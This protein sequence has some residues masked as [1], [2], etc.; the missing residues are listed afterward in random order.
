MPGASP[1]IFAVEQSEGTSR[2]RLT[3]DFDVD[4]VG[5]GHVT[6]STEVHGELPTEVN[7]DRCRRLAN[8]RLYRHY[9]STNARPRRSKTTRLGGGAWKTRC[10]RGHA[11]R[12]PP[13]SGETPKSVRRDIP[14][15]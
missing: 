12:M 6:T 7:E 13:T 10:T 1:L 9:Y 11:K 8:Q 14:A 15:F 4:G 3:A 2:L 5:A